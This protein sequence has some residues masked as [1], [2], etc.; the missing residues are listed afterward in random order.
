M[1]VYI[2]EKPSLGRTIAQHLT[3]SGKS[4]NNRTHIVGDGWIVTWC[5][6]H[7]YELQTPSDY[8]ENWAGG[9]SLDQLPMIPSELIYKPKESA[10]AQIKVIND[11]SKKASVLYNCADP[12]REGEMLV[13]NVINRTGFTGP[14]YRVWPDDISP[15]GLVKVFNKI[16]PASEYLPLYQAAM[17]RAQADWLVGMNFTRLFTCIAG[18]HGGQTVV[19]LGRVQSVVFSLIY[20]RCIEIENFRPINHFTGS[21]LFKVNGGEYKGNLILSD[22]IKS[23]DGYVLDKSRLDS[24]S[25]DVQNAP[26]KISSVNKE[27]KVEKPTL[28]FSLTKLQIHASKKWGYTAKQVLSACQYLYEDLKALTYPRSECGYLSEGEFQEAP[29]LMGVISKSVDISNVESEINTSV[30]PKAFD[31]SKTEAHTGIIPTL[32][33]P[34][35]D[36]FSNLSDKDK[37]SK[38]IASVDVL[39]NIYTAASI[40][41]VKQFLPNYEYEQTKVVTAVG[42]HNFSTTGNIV[43]QLGWKKLDPVSSKKTEELPALSNGDPATLSKFT[44]ESKKTK[45]PEYFNDGTL[46]AAMTNISQ[47]ISDPESKRK[48]KDTAGIGTAATRPD[49]IEKIKSVGYV[50][51]DKASFKLTQFGRDIQPSF[52]AY[53][54]TAT[55]TAIWETALEKIADGKVDHNRFNANIVAWTKTNVEELIA[56]PPTMNITINSKYKCPNCDKPLLP[57]KGKFGNYWACSDRDCR[58]SFKEFQKGPLFPIEGDGD[59]CSKCA[60]GTMQTRSTSGT[61]DKPASVFLG[62]KNYPECKNSIWPTK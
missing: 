26:A 20:D 62:C 33:A 47:F 48:L 30:M 24:I 50:Y 17:S 9:W 41:Y 42:S 14:V 61:K 49:I 8:N 25:L 46:I 43:K 5:F 23:V 44:I 40:Q 10:K 11:L 6:G 60:D 31:D 28:P 36:T 4:T 37:K 12:D 29:L 13:S 19:S 58:T 39:K 34:N 56:N 59:K 45:P 7:L 35:F 16:K 38:N 2:A 53:F 21:A 3:G 54:K 18:K 22:S 55:M 32:T 57:K 15:T 27:L 52:P 1:D 51:V